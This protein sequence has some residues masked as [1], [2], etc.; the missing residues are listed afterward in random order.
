MYNQAMDVQYLLC[1]LFEKLGLESERDESCRRHIELEEK[2]R[3]LEVVIVDP[4][5]S[6]ILELVARISANIAIPPS[7]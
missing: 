5:V 4:E 7:S 1:V 6:K 3:E 2:I